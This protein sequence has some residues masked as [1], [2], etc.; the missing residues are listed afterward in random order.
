M[1][2]TMSHCRC[3]LIPSSNTLCSSNSTFSAISTKTIPLAGK[4]WPGAFKWNKSMTK[5]LIMVI[6]WLRFINFSL[7]VERRTSDWEVAGSTP[8]RA[9][10]RNNLRQ[11]V[12]TLMS[13]WPSSISWHR[14]RQHPNYGD[15]L[16][17]K[18]SS[19][20]DCVTQCS[21]SAVHLHEQFL[22]V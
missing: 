10:L 14:C 6:N 21:Q 3:S 16:E 18:N 15:C 1:T 19:V 20:L 9:L 17:V 7:R 5:C 8:A 11:V 4:R 22:Q 13:L 12:D 2:S